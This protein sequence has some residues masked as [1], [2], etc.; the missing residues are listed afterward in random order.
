[1]FDVPVICKEFQMRLAF[2]SSFLEYK[3]QPAKDLG[4]KTF[5]KVNLYALSKSLNHSRKFSHK[6]LLSTL[7]KYRSAYCT[8]IMLING[9]G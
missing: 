7:L 4:E 6:D 1:M 2:L 5:V 3:W 9:L 8:A